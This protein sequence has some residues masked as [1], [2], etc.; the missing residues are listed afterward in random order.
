MFCSTNFV[1]LSAFKPHNSSFLSVGGEGGFFCMWVLEWEFGVEGS[2]LGGG[3]QQ[4]TAVICMVNPT[5]G[6]SRHF[7]CCRQGNPS[8]TSSWRV[9]RATPP[10]VWTPNTQR[11]RDSEG[12]RV[13]ERG[14]EKGGVCI[15]LFKHINTSTSH[16]P[17]N[18]V[19]KA[20][21]PVWLPSHTNK[22][23][24]PK[25]NN[26][27]PSQTSLWINI[28]TLELTAHL[29]CYY[30]SHCALTHFDK[31]KQQCKKIQKKKVLLPS[32]LN[33]N[34]PILSLI[35]P[36]LKKKK[37]RYMHSFTNSNMHTTSLFFCC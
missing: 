37:N 17:S 4:V 22:V 21:F 34:F 24:C 28:H 12:V 29:V 26:H 16:L 5:A 7:L 36:S 2:F 35:L 31:K 15:R 18:N 1:Q 30:N 13:S 3:W 19:H 8:H 27:S 23:T 25:T 6:D 11:G 32:E 9:S 33:D 14:K 20:T 10:R